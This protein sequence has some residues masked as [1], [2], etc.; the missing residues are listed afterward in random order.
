MNNASRLK[1]SRRRAAGAALAVVVAIAATGRVWAQGSG[2]EPT[3]EQLLRVG[4][5]EIAPRTEAEAKKLL[6]ARVSGKVVITSIA[7]D[8]SRQNTYLIKAVEDAPKIAG[9]FMRVQQNHWIRINVT[10][11]VDQ[12]TSWALSHGES[13]SLSGSVASVKFLTDQNF[14]T[15]GRG[16]DNLVLLELDGLKLGIVE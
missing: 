1:L 6:G 13:V 9:A 8:P 5:S 12:Q 7:S 14:A 2:I 15:G 11:S 10:F 3:K 16:N 4:F